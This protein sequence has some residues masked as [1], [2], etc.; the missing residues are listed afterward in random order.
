[1]W[2]GF[3]SRC[4]STIAHSAPETPIGGATRRVF[5]LCKAINVAG[6]S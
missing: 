5:P 3:Q 2:G 4:D 1:M 6:A